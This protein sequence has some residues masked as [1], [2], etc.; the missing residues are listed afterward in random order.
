MIEY[1][2]SGQ[3]LRQRQWLQS[4]V[5]GN[6][7]SHL[8][9]FP[10][11]PWEA[12]Q[13]EKALIEA[14]HLYLD[15][16]REIHW[17]ILLKKFFEIP[18]RGFLPYCSFR[19][20]H[21]PGEISLRLSAWAFSRTR[22]RGLPEV[23]IRE[24]LHE[25]NPEDI[26]NLS[27]LLQLYLARGENEKVV[28]MVEKQEPENGRPVFAR[29]KGHALFYLGRMEEAAEAYHDEAVV[30]SKERW[31]GQ[32]H[33]AAA[34]V[35]LNK[36]QPAAESFKKLI[37]EYP[38]AQDIHYYYS[39][40]E[41]V[42]K[43]IPQSEAIY[44][45]EEKPGDSELSFEE[46]PKFPAGRFKGAP[47]PVTDRW[48]EYWKFSRERQRHL[49]RLE[50]AENVSCPV[51][52]VEE[53]EYFMVSPA[54]GFTLVLCPECGHRFARP[55]PT[56]EELHLLYE[57]EYFS[58]KDQYA[59]RILAALE[60]NKPLTSEPAYESL[61]EWLDRMGWRQ[62]ELERGANRRA[63]D[64][65]CA[66]GACLVALKLRGWTVEGQDI[67]GEYGDYFEQLE[68]PYHKIPLENIPAENESFDLVTMTH[69]IEHLAE[70]AKTIQWCWSRLKP[71][72][73][74]V[75]MTPAAGTVAAWL[76]G[77]LWYA[78]PEHV[79]FF[80][81]ESLR[82][83]GVQR[84]GLKPLYFRTRVGVEVETPF[85][86]WRRQGIGGSLRALLEMT[87]QGDVV[88]MVMEK[89]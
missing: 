4:I 50:G 63:L 6:I 60:E 83:L 31:L 11:E 73:R 56:E 25:L 47:V 51:C 66:S 74:L 57:K 5:E 48:V 54:T 89:A 30:P 59:Q 86:N 58:G 80:T 37:D 19:L 12:D 41:V 32:V 46:I 29:E 14:L 24:K 75:V 77:P 15:S 36:A 45:A 68:I 34:L 84:V 23:V 44:F 3:E 7:D 17:K 67:G 16:P 43:K 72:G 13:T 52:G 42:L 27:Q 49:A 1:S 20:I 81:P 28:S 65:G 87:G 64:I 62:W 69:V 38:D 71:G 8:R 10:W 70:P 9:D 82:L 26:Q 21:H 39:L 2:F 88:E 55:M 53:S 79:Q 61:F 76:G 35:F 18:R 78:V 33:E 40:E 22:S 85:R